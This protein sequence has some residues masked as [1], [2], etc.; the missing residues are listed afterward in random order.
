MYTLDTI[1]NI[2]FMHT[3]IDYIKYYYYLCKYYINIIREK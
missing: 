1:Y 2:R 3:K